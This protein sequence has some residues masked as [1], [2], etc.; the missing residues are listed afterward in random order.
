MRQVHLLV[1]H[2]PAGLDG[3]IDRPALGHLERRVILHHAILVLAPTPRKL[4]VLRLEHKLT[5]AVTDLHRQNLIRH[6]HSLPT[7]QLGAFAK[8]LHVPLV[9]QNRRLVHDDLAL[10]QLPVA[11]VFGHPC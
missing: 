5:S 11:K 7:Y 8:H 9:C 3:H 6:V 1:A 10:V 2:G 4:G